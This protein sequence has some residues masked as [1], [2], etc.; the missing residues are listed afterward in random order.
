MSSYLGVSY[1]RG[2][3]TNPPNNHC[4]VLRRGAPQQG[5]LICGK[6]HLLAVMFDRQFVLFSGSVRCYAIARSA[7]SLP[8]S[9]PLLF[10]ELPRSER[11]LLQKLL[12]V[13]KNPSKILEHERV[14]AC[15]LGIPKARAPYQAG[16]VPIGAVCLQP[17][18]Q[19]NQ[20][21]QNGAGFGAMM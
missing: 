19:P 4:I 18:Q 13:L 20:A 6:P 9:S 10:G 2:P 16:V 12:G 14:L 21:S 11:L 17:K 8:G 5:P 15:K 1:N 7:R 3:L